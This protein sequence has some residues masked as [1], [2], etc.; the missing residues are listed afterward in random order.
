MTLT[1]Q[2]LSRLP[3]DVLSGLRKADGLWAK[4]KNGDIDSTAVVHPS[5]DDL[6]QIE[7]DVVICGGTLGIF[8]GAALA[9]RGW[10]VAL[11]ERGELKGREQEWN[12]SR[13][14]LEVF[15]TLGLLSQQE[16]EGAIA[17]AYNPGR[18]AF[19]KGIEIW[20]DD[21]LNIGVDPVQLLA[22]LKQ[23]FIQAGGTLLEYTSFKEATVCP[24]GVCLRIE[25]RNLSPGNSSSR[26]ASREG[27]QIVEPS[28]SELAT[29]LTTRLVI[30]AMGHFSPIARQ[31]RQGQQPDSVCLVVGTC[32]EGYPIQQSDA[33]TGDLFASITSIQNNCQ[34]FWEAF[35][36][37]DGRTTYL[38]TYVDAHPERLSL[39]A[40]FEDYWTLLP[41]YQHCSREDLDIKR[42]L[43]GF[44]PCYR[45]SPLQLP[46]NRFVAIGDSSGNQS[47]LSFGGFG[48]M[49]RHLSRITTAIHEALEDDC[50]TK[51]DLA[52]IQ[53]YQPNVSVTWLFQRSMSVRLSQTPPPNQIN[54]LLSGVFEAMEQLGEPVLKPFLQDVIQ[55][56]PLTRA[57]MQTSLRF[58]LL[59]LS[60][61]PYVGIWELLEWS[62]HYI[63]LGIYTGLAAI[64]QAI[65]PYLFSDKQP[66][67]WNRWVDAWIY[68]SGKDYEH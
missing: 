45:D 36:A 14:E 30:D 29:E 33:E 27:S 44:F 25:S 20:V 15:R 65:Q 68:G 31:A 57:L 11:I 24:N 39:E 2:Q 3:N 42:A 5:A 1:E 66:Y 49:V 67:T 19:H 17:T 60:I 16:L 40:L 12:I 34:Y 10:K 54:A 21:V 35:P 41:E 22:T 38:F 55:F 32:A 8:L 23:K 18:V 43:F 13:K 28:G 58:P 48:A 53:P 59:G 50:L 46:W 64:A 56:W 9:Q 47:P 62:R 7:W 63:S 37:K 61:I 6:A 4:Y 51:T 52:L 26:N